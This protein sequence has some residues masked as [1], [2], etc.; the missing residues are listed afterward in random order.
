VNGHEETLENFSGKSSMS[1]GI[2]YSFCGGVPWKYCGCVYFGAE[3]A[4][5]GRK[6][7]R[8]EQLP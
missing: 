6:A 4:R 8:W 5:Y 2:A 1:A 3:R 7:V